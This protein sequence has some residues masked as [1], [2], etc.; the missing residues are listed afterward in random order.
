MLPLV[1]MDLR[2]LDFLQA[3]YSIGAARKMLAELGTT[4]IQVRIEF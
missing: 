1:S 4:T 3:F 2:G